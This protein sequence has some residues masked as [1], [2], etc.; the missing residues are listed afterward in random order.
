MME[1]RLREASQMNYKKVITSERAAK[2]Y[3]GKFKI[4]LQGL[5]R[6]SDLKG[7]LF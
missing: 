3:A 1:S 2:E 7:M 4:E 6:A 5:K